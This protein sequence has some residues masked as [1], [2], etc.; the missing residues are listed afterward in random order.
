MR[1]AGPALL[2]PN[3]GMPPQR[4]SGR[5]KSH[6]LPAYCHR[7]PAV[8]LHACRRPR[9]TTNR[10]R[11]PELPS[12]SACRQA[13]AAA[14][15]RLLQTTHSLPPGFRPAGRRPPCRRSCAMSC[16]Q[17]LTPYRPLTAF[18]RAAA[19]VP[20]PAHMPAPPAAAAPPSDPPAPHGTAIPLLLLLPGVPGPQSRAASTSFATLATAP[21]KPTALARPFR[22]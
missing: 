2:A 15:S 7:S 5:P 14:A 12:P 17:G 20:R 3:A 13:P 21:A 8:P 19:A 16:T 22:R 9:Q 4:Q 1:S 10:R 6:R 11:T 18:R